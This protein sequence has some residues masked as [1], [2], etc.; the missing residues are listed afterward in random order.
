[1]A[2]PRLTARRDRTEGGGSIAAAWMGLYAVLTV[3]TSAIAQPMP[4]PAIRPISPTVVP[5]VPAPS[6]PPSTSTLPSSLSLSAAF[7][8]D[9]KPIRSGIVWRIYEDRGANT[10]PELVVKLTEPTPSRSLP[11]GTYIVHAAYG[12]ASVTKR[13]TTN[14]LDISERLQ[15]SAG[16]LR[17]GGSIGDVPIPPNRLS[18]SIFQPLSN[19]SEG[20]LIAANVKAGELVRLPDGMYHVVSTYGE[21]NAINRADLKVDRGRITDATL[22]HRAA[23]LT[24]KLVVSPGGEAFAGTAFSILTPGGD[25]I[26]EAIGA[27]PTVTLAEGEYMLIARHNGQ[28]YTREFKVE[29]GLDRDVEALVTP[30]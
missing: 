9:T 29:S 10:P 18:F 11:P 8:G 12:L 1:M 26:R 4:P 28:V 13:V 27:F 24:L 14:G 25:V 6:I 16:G 7:V 22:N 30:G 19:D 15:I 23:T 20:K 5:A 17:L 2:T 21:S 3:A